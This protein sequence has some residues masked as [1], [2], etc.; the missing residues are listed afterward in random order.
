MGLFKQIA[1][2]ILS[3]LTLCYSGGITISKHYCKADL[4]DLAVNT[5]VQ[6]CKGAEKASS[7]DSSTGYTEKSCCSDVVASFQTNSFNQT[8]SFVDVITFTYL[9]SA[10]VPI[11]ATK[12]PSKL[13]AIVNGLAPPLSKRHWHILLERFLI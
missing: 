10:Y 6:K 3:A 1:V 13:L 2:I 11:L 4:I 8:T 9:V 5:P 12:Q 7:T